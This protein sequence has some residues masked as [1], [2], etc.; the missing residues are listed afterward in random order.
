MHPTLPLRLP[1]QFASFFS[2][3][4]KLFISLRSSFSSLRF[5]VATTKGR[6]MRYPWPR[7]EKGDTQRYLENLLLITFLCWAIHFRSTCSAPDLWP[8]FFPPMTSPGKIYADLRTIA[9]PARKWDLLSGIVATVWHLCH[10]KKHDKK[11]ANDEQLSRRIF[12]YF[13]IDD[14]KLSRS[15]IKFI[16]PGIILI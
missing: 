3:L 13:D 15:V 2:F 12:S 4:W 6:A 10:G 1:F 9:I 7:K 11:H 14:S 5:V 8:L 16:S